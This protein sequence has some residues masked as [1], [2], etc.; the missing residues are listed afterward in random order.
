MEC[1]SNIGCQWICHCKNITD[2]KVCNESTCLAQPNLACVFSCSTGCSCPSCCQ[3]HP[4]K[5]I[6]FDC[7]SLHMAGTWECNKVV[8]GHTCQWTCPCSD[9]ENINT[10]L[11]STCDN[12]PGKNCTYN[13]SCFCT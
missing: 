3:D 8:N 9:I 11:L 12:N 2:A 13:N 7:A 1:N 6:A 5:N 10:C 4:N